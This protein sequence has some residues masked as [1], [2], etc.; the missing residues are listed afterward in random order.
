MRNKW[1]R[2]H[3][4]AVFYGEAWHGPAL[5]PTLRQIGIK[6]ALEE[7]AEGCAPWKVALYCAD[8]KF[9]VRK[10][11]SFDSAQLCFS[12]SPEDF[13]DLPGERTAANWERGVIFLEAEHQRLQTAVDH[14][15]EDQ[16]HN[17]RPDDRL[18]YGGLIL[19]VAGHDV[20]HTAHIRN[21]G[22]HIFQ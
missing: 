18:T 8:W 7:N 12:G 10:A 11:L 9:V 15:P 4:D 20:S 2:E 6:V 21:M 1:L 16:L 13:P 5:L 3:L 14:F 22:V 19:A 17:E